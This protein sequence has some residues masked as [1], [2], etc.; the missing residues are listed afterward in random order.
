MSIEQDLHLTRLELSEK[1]KQLEQCKARI[2]LLETAG[3]EIA[4]E[5]FQ[6]RDWDKFKAILSQK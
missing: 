6:L 2:A 1:Q 4:N 3:W 5:D